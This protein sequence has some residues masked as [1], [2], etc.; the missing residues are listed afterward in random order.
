LNYRNLFYHL[1]TLLKNIS[2]NQ[3]VNMMNEENLA[4]VFAPNILKNA[5]NSVDFSNLQVGNQ[6]V[7]FM[8]KYFPDYLSNFDDYI[9]FSK[10]NYQNYKKIEN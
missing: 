8:I 10:K 9:I 1:F 6:V 3:S 5:D 4:V 7:T 2:S